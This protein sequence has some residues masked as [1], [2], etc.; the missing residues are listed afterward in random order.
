MVDF[1][2]WTKESVATQQLFFMAVAFRSHPSIFGIYMFPTKAY[3]S[4]NQD[5]FIIWLYCSQGNYRI[6]LFLSSEN[7]LDVGTLFVY[8]YIYNYVNTKK[9]PIFSINNYHHCQ[10]IFICMFPQIHFDWRNLMYV[11][12]YSKNMPGS[13]RRK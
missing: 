6:C 8:W 9:I 10:K 7:V 4:S 11:I 2:L 5:D 13:I 3:L 12:W 1:R